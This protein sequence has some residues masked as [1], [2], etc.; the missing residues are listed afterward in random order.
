L[1]T[2]IGGETTRLASVYKLA[3]QKSRLL[4]TPR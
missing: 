4:I 1:I 2:V 3:Y